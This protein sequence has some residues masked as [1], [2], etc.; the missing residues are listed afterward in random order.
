M[1]SLLDTWQALQDEGVMELV[2][3][4]LLTDF[5]SGK[6]AAIGPVGLWIWTL[7]K[8]AAL[9][10]YRTL[11]IPEDIILLPPPGGSGE[12]GCLLG[13]TVEV[14][15]FRQRPFQGAALARLS[16][17]LAR[18]ISRKLG[19]ETSR[20]GLG[21]PAYKPLWDEW[22]SGLGWGADQRANLEQVL[23]GSGAAAPLAPNG[24][25]PVGSCSYRFSYQALIRLSVGN[26]AQRWRAG[27][28]KKCGFSL[29][30]LAARGRRE[31]N[32]RSR[33]NSVS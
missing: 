6:R 27:W 32:G 24:M 33:N 30:A 3:G 12:H 18:D 9:R 23:R 2:Q 15:V 4:T 13:A 26:L 11:A 1:A 21:V 19:L 14:A 17:E 25:K 28:R 31:N 7:K 10:G 20:T 29:R 22:L 16:M 5:L 8:E